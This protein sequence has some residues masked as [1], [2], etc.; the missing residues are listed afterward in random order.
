MPEDCYMA[1]AVA[2]NKEFELLNLQAIDWNFAS[3]K[4]SHLTHGLHP[5]PAKYIPQIPHTL[6]K[7]LSSPGETVADIFCGSGTALVEALIL[8]RNAVGVDANPLAC[9]ISE[10]KTIRLIERDFDSLLLIVERARILADQISDQSKATLFNFH[11]FVSTAY[12]PSNDAISFWFESFV[13]EELAE[14][15]AWCRELPTESSRKVALTA[16]SSII[17]TV[18]KQD[19]DTRYVRR[20]KRIQ[21]GDVLRRFARTL[22]DAAR[23]SAEFTKLVDPNLHCHIYNADLLTGPD[24]GQADLVV[25]SPPYPNAYSYH[26]YHMTRMLWLGMDQPKFKQEEI[27]SHRKYSR[28]GPNGATVET[29]R[30]EMSI[31]FSWLHRHLRPNRYACFVV[32]HSTLKGQI[33]N[34]AD[35]ISDVAAIHGFR[36]VCRIER[37]MQDTKKAFNPAIGRIKHEQIVVMSKTEGVGA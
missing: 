29:F 37:R 2:K 9:L 6:I 17:V 10:A 1:Q 26:L 30:N 31:I 12:R 36:E 22:S 3:A 27:G 5:Y 28:K 33:V 4:T 15:L 11:Q 20:E 25:C 14:A 21:P 8:G 13:V 23:N 19:S 7:E 18:S 32:G 16:F 35:L 34:N 24:I